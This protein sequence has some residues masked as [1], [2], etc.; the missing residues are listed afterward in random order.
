MRAVRSSTGTELEGVGG[1]L[2][3]ALL[4]VEARHVED[5]LFGVGV[6][7][8]GGLELRLGLGGVVVEAVELAEEEMGLDVVGLELGELLVLGDGE[9]QHLAGLGGL[10][11]AEGT[12]IDLAEQSHGLRCRWGCG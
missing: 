8:L 4:A 9:L 5:D 12:E 3:V 2:E 11:V 10:H 7:L 6:D 1:T